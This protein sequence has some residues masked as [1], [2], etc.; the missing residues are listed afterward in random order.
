[1]QI[2]NSNAA[3]SNVSVAASVDAVNE[4]TTT[5]TQADTLSHTMLPDAFRTIIQRMMPF[6]VEMEGEVL[7]KLWLVI[8]G[9]HDSLYSEPCQRQYSAEQRLER[10]TFFRL[11]SHFVATVIASTTTGLAKLKAAV[12][13]P[14]N[15]LTPAHVAAMTEQIRFAQWLLDEAH[16][17]MDRAKSSTQ[18]PS[19]R[20]GASYRSR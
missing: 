1:M 20:G 2:E 18:R 10:P 7:A 14:S 8:D 4:N 9:A 6:V 15:A 5:S 12:V 13:R 16:D 11:Y 19:M 3:N 17:E